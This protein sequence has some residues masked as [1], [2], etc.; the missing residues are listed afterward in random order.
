MEKIQINIPEGHEIDTQ[1][2]DLAKGSI[3]FKKIVPAQILSFKDILENEGGMFGYHLSVDGMHLTTLTNKTRNDTDCRTEDD[4]KKVLAFI[5]YLR[6]ASYYNNKYA[7][8]WKPDWKD[9]SEKYFVYYDYS[10]K[11]YS[12]SS[13]QSHNECV[14]YFAT[15]ELAKMMIDNNRDI[16]DEFYQINSK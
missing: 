3:F 5:K 4:A 8:G 15:K 16:L 1:K 6:V 7:G 9:M 11:R 14:I 10:T 12:V 13:N 2:S